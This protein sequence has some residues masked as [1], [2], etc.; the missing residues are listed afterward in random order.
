MFGFWGGNKGESVIMDSMKVMQLVPQMELGGVERGVVDLS[1][2]L[3]GAGYESMV[4]SRGGALVAGLRAHGGV[5]VRFDIGS[6]NVL[7]APRRA[8]QL[9]RLW[10]REAPD[11]IHVR[12]RAPM[13]L[14]R[15][16]GAAAGGAAPFKIVSTLHGLYRVNRYSAQMTHADCVICPSTAAQEYARSQFGVAEDQL[17]LIARGVD[18]EEFCA[19]AEND[20][21]AELRQEWQ[22]NEDDFLVAMVGRVSALKG[23]AFFMRALAKVIAAQKAMDGKNPGQRRRVVG[24]VVG[25]GND[26]RLQQLQATIGALGIGAQVRLVGV[27]RNMAAVYRAVDLL[28]SASQKPESFGRVMAE[29][30]SMACPVVAS[31]HGGALDIIQT[32]ENAN[33][34]GFLFPPADEDA[35]AAAIG[36]AMRKTINQQWVGLRQSVMHFSVS[37]MT[38]K[39][40][41]VYQELLV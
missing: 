30:L 34:N 40:I 10:Q 14:L 3:V 28:V 25:G 33:T 38:T 22:V 24:I 9:R 1:K 18:L 7:S 29:A 8:W 41:A 31:A 37:A 11:I 5:H 6:K 36:N 27:H 21:R 39:T 26:A 13:W 20:C 23:H 35:C 19:S 4:V 2:A 32:D 16:S 12:S 15:L 17:R